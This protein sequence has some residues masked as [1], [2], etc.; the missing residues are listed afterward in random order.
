M[1]SVA[2][3]KLIKL[4]TDQKSLSITTQASVSTALSQAVGF[5]YMFKVYITWLVFLWRGKGQGGGDGVREEERWLDRHRGQ[6]QTT[7]RKSR[8]YHLSSTQQMLFSLQIVGVGENRFVS[9]WGEVRMCFWQFSW[10]RCWQ[11]GGGGG[12]GRKFR[13]KKGW[14]L[15]WR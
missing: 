7:G 11:W 6:I 14:K 3:E 15:S 13:K 9:V 8:V 10:L 5:I 12:G 4:D 1:F 2:L